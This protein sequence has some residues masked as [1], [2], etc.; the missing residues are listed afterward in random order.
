[1]VELKKIL[2]TWMGA[3]Q[4]V[5]NGHII[6]LEWLAKRN[7]YPTIISAEYATYRG[8]LEG[9]KWLYD[10]GYDISPEVFNLADKLNKMDIAD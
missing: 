3:N 1:M 8:N 9:I 6:I 2:P 5:A 10:N 4:A 7:I